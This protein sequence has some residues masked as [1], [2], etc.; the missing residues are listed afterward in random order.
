[1]PITAALKSDWSRLRLHTRRTN[2][3]DGP[4]TG[5][6]NDIGGAGTV[7][8]AT[9]QVLATLCAILNYRRKAELAEKD[10]P[11]DRLVAD[12]IDRGQ[13]AHPICA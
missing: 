7:S 2:N 10:R 11:R 9:N 4:K 6:D 12:L 5:D 13:A 3:G 8:W 1:M